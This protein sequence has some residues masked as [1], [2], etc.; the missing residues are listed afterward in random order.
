MSVSDLIKSAVDKDAGAFESSFNSVM[1]DK[2]TA[3]IETK[4]DSM[5]GASTD[6]VEVDVEAD[7]E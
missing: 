3:A 7:T 6:S 2:M 5:F 4:Y 1:A